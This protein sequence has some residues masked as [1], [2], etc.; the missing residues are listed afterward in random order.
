MSR[1]KDVDNIGL[2]NKDTEIFLIFKIQQ[3][4]NSKITAK[5]YFLENKTK[6]FK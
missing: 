6:I 2:E 3:L 4:P 5:C 1:F